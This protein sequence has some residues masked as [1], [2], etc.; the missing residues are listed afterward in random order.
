MF[1]SVK[2][3]VWVFD[4]EWVPDPEAGRRLF[5]L[6]ED[7][8]DIDVLKQMWEEGGA[9]EENLIPYLKNS[10]CRVVSIA[11]VILTEK[12]NGNVALS[13]TSLPHKV[14]DPKQTAEV[15]IIS[16]FLNAVGDKKP[17]LA[18]FNSAYT[19]LKLLVQRATANFNTS[20]KIR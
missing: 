16:S 4:V 14:D 15:E 8:P 12:G 3:D 6:P 18:G 20:S 11:A 2:K 17:Q 19:D 13:L 10:I 9:D 1:K 7:T 5:E